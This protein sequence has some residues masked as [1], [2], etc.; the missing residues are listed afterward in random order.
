VVEY[1]LGAVNL[2][3]YKGITKNTL[4]SDLNIQNL[5]S[6]IYSNEK[7]ILEIHKIKKEIQDNAHTLLVIGVGG[8]FLGARA[9]IDS[10]TSYFHKQYDMEFIYAGYNMSGAYLQ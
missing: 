4:I 9:V 8:S 1:F 5:N 2:I 7:N 3:N 10:L 6:Y